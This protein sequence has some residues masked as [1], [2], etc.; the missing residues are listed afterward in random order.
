MGILPP[1]LKAGAVTMALTVE[2]LM[3]LDTGP[4]STACRHEVLPWYILHNEA[5]GR[6]DQAVVLG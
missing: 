2:A 6:R 5:E 4:S 3:L 1:G